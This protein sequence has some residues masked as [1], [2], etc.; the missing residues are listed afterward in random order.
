MALKLVIEKLEDVD[1]DVRSLY[2]EKDGKFRLDVDGVEDTTAMKAALAR[3]NKEAGDR[4]KQIDR[5]EKI[6]KT[7]EEI[8]ELLAK[9]DEDK[10]KAAHEKG[11]VEAV[12][13]QMLD[14]FAKERKK[15]E[16]KI[17]EAEVKTGKMRSAMESQMIDATATA[18][19]VE[20]KGDPFML[21]HHVQRFAKVEEAD[22]G[23]YMIKVMDPLEG[24]EKVNGEGK[25]M[26]IPE[27]VAEMSQNERYARAFVGNG[28][29]G[30]GSRQQGGGE[31]PSTVKSKKELDT[32]EKRMAFVKTFPSE[33]AGM[34]AYDK[35]PKG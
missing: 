1:E 35:L 3:A 29:S 10:D 31:R 7:A 22:D 11:D 21:L 26:T 17:A 34:D 6:G 28:H 27:L 23:K 16:D 2:K 12:K 33:E 24:T 32:R 30:G 8:E 4:R 25:P 14:Q 9:I 20:A 18:A 19:I 15:L 5:W 13:K